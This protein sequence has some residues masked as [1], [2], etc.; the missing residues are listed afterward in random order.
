MKLKLPQLTATLSLRTGIDGPPLVLVA[1]GR[2]QNRTGCG[3]WLRIMMILR[4]GPLTGASI[5]VIRTVLFPAGSWETL[6]APSRPAGNGRSGRGFPLTASLPPKTLQ[7][8]SWLFSFLELTMKTGSFWPPGPSAA[9]L[10]MPSACSIPLQ[11]MD[12]PA[13]W[14]TIRR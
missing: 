11:A 6:T 4:F 5:P 7:I 13:A 12:G 9:A 1:G 14:P 8:S 10:T 2:P 3:S